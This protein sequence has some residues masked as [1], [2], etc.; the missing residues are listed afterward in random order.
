[1]TVFR[2]L[3]F[4]T[5]AIS[6]ILAELWLA[7]TPG[8]V[9]VFWGNYRIDTSLSLVLH[10]VVVFCLITAILYR[11][12]GAAKR[13]PKEIRQRA[14][15]R[16]QRR[17]Y[18]ALGSSL[19]SCASGN[20]SEALRYAKKASALLDS[21]PSAKLLEAQAA[22]L[23]GDSSKVRETFQSL[24]EEP[25]T[26]LL[27]VRGLM[28]EA[29]RKGDLSEALKLANEAYRLNPYAEGLWQQRLEIQIKRRQWVE[30]Y[31]AVCEAV[32]S[33]H[34]SSKD[35]K[36]RRAVILYERACIA[37]K[38]GEVDTQ[39]SLL[40]DAVKLDTQFVIATAKLA[41][42][43]SVEGNTEK[44]S[45]LIKKLWSKKP[46]PALAAVYRSLRPDLD[47][48]MQ[49]KRFE[50]LVVKNPSHHESH[51]AI[52]EAALAAKLWG[53]A[54]SKLKFILDKGVITRRVCNLMA[55]VEEGEFGDMEQSHYWSRQKVSALPD[56][57]WIC[58]S[59]GVEAS[60]WQGCCKNCNSFDTLVWKRPQPV[61]RFSDHEG[62]S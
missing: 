35:G 46:H 23:A 25:E 34:I 31:E 19:I 44:A 33:K 37:E 27:G 40:K 22:Q 2:I 38:S 6:V 17:G 61:M 60:I 51:I 3:I 48:I 29:L 52:A 9:T 8:E 7:T 47:P 32:R 14:F 5:V 62:L 36:R 39:L 58:I 55:K 13:A 10:V 4:L 59:C 1:M 12:W 45:R 15:L 18:E 26:A 57:A 41:E 49:V 43:L 24:M 42:C 54:R 11:I 56:E 53:E 21:P 50:S 20:P 16:N 28:G 30:A